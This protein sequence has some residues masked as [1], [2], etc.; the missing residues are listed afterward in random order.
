M[1]A[2]I[3]PAE[4]HTPPRNPM[5]NHHFPF[6]KNAHKMAQITHPISQSDRPPLARVSLIAPTGSLAHF[7]A[8]S[9]ALFSL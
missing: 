7:S 5:R 6:P 8:S 2:S 9:S 1:I 4:T 3:P